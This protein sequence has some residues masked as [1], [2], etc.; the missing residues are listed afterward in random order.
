MDNFQSTGG[1]YGKTQDGKPVLVTVES[2]QYGTRTTLLTPELARQYMGWMSRC[3]TPTT[4]SV[5]GRV[6]TGLSQYSPDN[7]LGEL[8]RT[9]TIS[10]CQTIHHTT[11]TQEEHTMNNQHTPGPWESDTGTGWIGRGK[12]R[13][14]ARVRRTSAYGAPDLGEEGSANA[15]LIAAAPDLLA[16]LVNTLSTLDGLCELVGEPL[17]GKSA[18]EARAAIAKA[19]TTQYVNRLLET[20]A[21]EE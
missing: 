13:C 8:Q 6:V 18:C 12:D 16:A 1:W 20:L 2:Y 7:T 21:T 19:T 4:W 9:H 15:R 14:I 11:T 5:S 3:P 17:W 10:T